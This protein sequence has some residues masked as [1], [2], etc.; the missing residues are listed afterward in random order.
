[1]SRDLKPIPRNIV[2]VEQSQIEAY[3]TNVGKPSSE[4]GTVFSQ[5][6]ATD[7][8][9]KN[10]KIKDI[11]IGLLDIDEAIQYYFDNTIKP[12]VIQNGVRLAVPVIYGDAEKWKSV[13][14][15]GFYRDHNGKIMA[16]LIMYRRTN[17]EKNRTLGNKLDGN[18]AHLFN[19][20]ETRYNKKNFYN[21]FDILTNTTPSKQYYVSVVPDYVTVTYECILFTNFIEQNNKLIEAIEYASDSYW[22]NF[23]KWYFKTKIDTFA[24]TNILEQD[25]DRA[26]KTNFTMT[27]NGYLIPDSVN[28]KASATNMFYSPSQV[29]FGVEVVG[30]ANE[31]F[32]AN[33]QIAAS[34]GGGNTSF[35]GGGTNITNTSITNN[36]TVVSGSL[37][38]GS[39]L[40]INVTKIAN[41]ITVPNTAVFTGTSIAQPVSGSL[42]PATS[43]SNFYFYINGQNIPSSYVTLEE[44]GGN[45]IFTFNTTA[46]GY[47]LVSTD[48]VVA[49]GK[50]A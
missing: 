15:D 39:Y 42:L 18:E 5:N 11:S 1:M 3:I 14:N 46:I 9:R 36:I 41:V 50:F 2:Q 17:L 29:V 23:K 22:G 38:D 7:I 10:D 28:A 48:E 40:N 34:Q 37:I 19:I 20:F 49:V 21:K 4:E 8:S 27:L 35:V 44:G 12:S 6:R 32:V 47:T 16:P 25:G 31:T 30:N 43:V 26:A 45:V 33:S 24:V 13:Q